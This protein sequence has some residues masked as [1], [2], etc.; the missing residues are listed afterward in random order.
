MD[1]RVARQS[2]LSWIAGLGLILIA[3]VALPGISQTS[4]AV[5]VAPQIME[6]TTTSLANFAVVDER[7][8]TPLPIASEIERVNLQLA[9]DDYQSDPNQW[10]RP[11][12]ESDIDAMRSEEFVAAMIKGKDLT[13]RVTDEFGGPISGVQLT[14][15]S[16][17]PGDHALKSFNA[18]P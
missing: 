7:E 5:A 16:R 1:Q 11:I 10:S 6:N 17:F 8:R 3:L 15:F 2:R 9:H 13:G 12:N 14:L 18:E 4:T